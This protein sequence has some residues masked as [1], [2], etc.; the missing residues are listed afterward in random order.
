[1]PMEGIHENAPELPSS[2]EQTEAIQSVASALRGIG[3]AIHNLYTLER[4]RFNK[5]YPEK[6]SAT[7]ATIT[8][9]QTEEERLRE[10]QGATDESIDEWMGRREIQFEATQARRRQKESRSEASRG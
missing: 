7:D 3:A 8:H 4:E 5:Q 2:R 10:E 9:R 1:M 6:R